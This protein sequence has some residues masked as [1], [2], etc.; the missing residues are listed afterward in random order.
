MRKFFWITII[1]VA[2]VALA[3]ISPWR[4]IRFDFAGLF[5]LQQQEK[6]SGLVVSSF[7]GKINVYIDGKL[8]GNATSDTPLVLPKVTP[9]DRLLK[10]ERETT[11]PLAYMTYSKLVAFLPGSEAQIS[12]EL[13]PSPEFSGG[14]LIYVGGIPT[15][16]K[17]NLRLNVKANTSDVE[18]FIDNGSIGKL[19][20]NSYQLPVKSQ[21]KLELR[22][23]GYE[24]Q[25]F[26]ILP[27]VQ[28]DRDKL[29]GLDLMVEVDL[30]LQPI[31][32]NLEVN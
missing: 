31:K 18:V 5:G 3:F 8:E 23:N 6:T 11:V 22:K 20:I 1:A 2:L 30:F 21:Y 9:G 27:E 13:G 15:S 24:T 28:A 32:L 17:A 26:T 29:G 4:Q 25:S 7:A 14:H 10:L 16:D 12:Y 19:P